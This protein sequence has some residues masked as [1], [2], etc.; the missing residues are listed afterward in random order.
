MV[1]PPPPIVPEEGDIERWPPG[2]P[3]SETEPFH[4]IERSPLLRTTSTPPDV[5]D[6]EMWD[7]LNE[8]FA[9]F[10]GGGLGCVCCG[11]AVPLEPPVAAC[12]LDDFEPDDFEADELE[13]DAWEPEDFE[14]EDFE[15]DF[16]LEDFEPDFELEDFEPDDLLLV[17]PVEVEELDDPSVDGV[18][19][20]PEEWWFGFDGST[21]PPACNALSVPFCVT[22]RT[23]MPPISNTTTATIAATANLRRPSP[24]SPSEPSRPAPIV[25]GALDG[26]VEFL[27]RYVPIPPDTEP[28]IRATR[29]GADPFG[30]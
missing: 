27:P 21:A 7:V 22:T 20:P 14:L 23:A 8:S 25:G 1:D 28:R 15:P 9:G 16:E 3:P 12:E 19:E 29:C 6:S 10:G 24:S 11:A 26:V 2:T 5:P 4:D 13:A 18:V 17:D 30:R